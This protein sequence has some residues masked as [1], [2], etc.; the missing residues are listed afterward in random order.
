MKNASTLL[1]SSGNLSEAW[2]Q[3]FLRSMNTARGVLPQLLVSIEGTGA[4]PIEDV[5]IRTALDAL[6]AETGNN[7]SS[8]SGM[9][10]FPYDLWVSKGR[11]KC[12]EFS[13]LCVDRLYERLRR[14][15]SRNAYGTYFE[16]MMRFRG[17]RNGTAHTVN[18]LEM[19]IK[20]LNRKRR[21]RESALQL[22]C[23]DPSK[24]HTGQAV[25]GFPCLH[26]ISV[27]YDANDDLHVTALYP[28]QYVFERAYGNYMGIYHLGTFIAHETN[29]R[30]KRM[31]CITIAPK[32]GDVGKGKLRPLESLVKQRLSGA[33]RP[34]DGTP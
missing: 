12:K 6:L 29:R 14:L 32:L 10:V 34:T 28:T 7:Y 25:R 18:Q 20:L 27:G 3:V 23:F 8:V 9:L 2:G 19:V 21:P 15:D 26:H 22:C 30:F 31:T 13:R 11:P 16:R 33:R 4:T 24:D 1:I 17:I 5:E